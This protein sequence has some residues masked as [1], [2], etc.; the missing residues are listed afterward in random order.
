MFRRLYDKT[1]DLAA[2]RHALP[3]LAL[4]AFAESSFFPIPP[5]VMLLPM[6]LADRK[7]AFLIA[8]VCT[9]GSVAGGVFGYMLG[10]GFW[11]VVG[12]YI[13]SPDKFEQFSGL[14]NTYGGW[15]VLL[16]GF[17][18]I[19]YKVF[20]IASGTVGLNIFVFILF[21][22]IGRG[23]R[24]FLEASLLYFFGAPIKA[25]IERYF[26]L[27]TLVAGALIVGA[28]IAYQTLLH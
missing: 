6:V 22:L 12:D 2:H 28:A 3:I 23:G 9:I 1:L 24:F 15:I 27:L 8:T 20:T 10:W 7:R 4:L 5:D 17:S 13:A 11:D 26:G 14:Y 18:P 16:A 25:F 19:P 21:S